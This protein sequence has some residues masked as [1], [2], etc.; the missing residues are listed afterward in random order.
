MLTATGADVRAKHLNSLK[1]P[2]RVGVVWNN[3]LW[4]PVV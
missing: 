1:A 2:F 4:H 3:A